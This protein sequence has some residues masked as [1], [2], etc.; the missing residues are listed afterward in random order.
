MYRGIYLPYC[1][2]ARHSNPL[3][4]YTVQSH[5]SILLITIGI[6]KYTLDVPLEVKRI[7]ERSH[8][9]RG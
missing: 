7:Q 4:T 9:G 1:I 2:H 8:H 6:P 5:D 3:Q